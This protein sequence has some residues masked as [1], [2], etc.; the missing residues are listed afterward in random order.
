[1][2]GL[3][4]PLPRSLPNRSGVPEIEMGQTAGKEGNQASN[5]IDLLTAK[6]VKDLSLD[7]GVNG[8]LRSAA[9]H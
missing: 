3:W 6:T 2:S 5:L 9:Q 1:M 8:G 4:P 7:V